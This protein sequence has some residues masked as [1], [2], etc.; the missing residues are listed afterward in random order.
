MKEQLLTPIILF[1]LIYLA[2]HDV[3]GLFEILN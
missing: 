3:I 1:E 2:R